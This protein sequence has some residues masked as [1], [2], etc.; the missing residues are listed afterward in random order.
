MT[1]FV[2]FWV[3][4][5]LRKLGFGKFGR[6]L[7]VAICCFFDSKIEREKERFKERE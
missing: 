5:G 4:F 2:V 1:I 6:D 7:G 3:G